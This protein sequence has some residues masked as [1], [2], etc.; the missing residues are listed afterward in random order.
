[1]RRD[2]NPGGGSSGTPASFAPANGF[3]VACYRAFLDRL[4]PAFDVRE[5]ELRACREGVAPPPPDLRWSHY[6]DDV[7]QALDG[8]GDEPVVGIGHSMGAVATVFAASR[9]PDLFRL[10]VLIEPAMVPLR[11]AALGPLLPWAI[12]GRMEPMKGALQRRDRWPDRAAYLDE[13]RRHP[14]FKRFDDDALRALADGAVREREGGV[15]LVF[16]KSWEA[17]AC[18]CPPWILP[19]LRRLET[20]VLALRGKPSVFLAARNRRRWE[21]AA[22]G[23]RFVDFPELGHLLPLEAPDRAADAVVRGVRS[24]LAGDSHHPGA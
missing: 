20:P 10:L 2:S 11:F 24:I 18:G 22:P 1:M 16:P 14:A 4:V 12:K 8:R 23:T 6:G 19:E 15:E 5:V 21:R 7:L 9:R 13:M 3:P 17:R